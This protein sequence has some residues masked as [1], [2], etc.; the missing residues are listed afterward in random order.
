RLV[1]GNTALHEELE[2][3]IARFKGTESAIL[4]NSGY[5]ANTGVIPVLAGDGDA[6]FSDSLN[7]GSIIDGCRLSKAN[8]YIYRHRDMDHLETLLRDAHAFRRKLIVTDGVFSMDGDLAPL[9]DLVAL[10]DKY[11]AILMVDDAHGTGVLG[12]Q[13]RG[14]A[15]HFGL[16]NRVPVMM[17]TLGKALGSMGAYVT[18]NRS[19]VRYLTSTARSFMFS[20]ALP[21]S[22]CAAAITA[23]DILDLERWRKDRLWKNRERLV[24]GLAAIGISTGSSETPILPIA[25]GQA[26]KTVIAASRLQE[27]GVFAT[28]IR[29]PT[30][31]VGASR[32]RATVMADHSDDDIDQ[33]ISAF[34]KLRSE[35]L[36]D[37]DQP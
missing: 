20:T 28:A 33:A 16:Q 8:T 18:G 17:G 26:D 1:S 15:E 3:K 11:S 32:I 37:H 10:S 29:P 24:L 6:I 23:L 34:G 7:H 31:P 12:E 36:F 14:T 13:G 30:V 5:A 19:L 22:A 25:V 4:F 2:H 9:P 27:E 35:G 21:P